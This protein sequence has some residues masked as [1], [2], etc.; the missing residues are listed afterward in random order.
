VGDPLTDLAHL[1]VYWESAK[2]RIT[3]ESQLISKLPGF[4]SGADMA[5]AYSTATGRSLEYLPFYLGFEHWRASIIKEAI[6]IRGTKGEAA[7][8][9]QLEEMERTVPLHLQEA[10]DILD[11]WQLS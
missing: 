1:L 5:Q 8:T 3:H 9:I 6:Y 2:G 4:M 11:G 10:A 7:E